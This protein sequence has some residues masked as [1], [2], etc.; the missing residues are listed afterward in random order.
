MIDGCWVDSVVIEDWKR[1]YTRRE[2]SKRRG[3]GILIVSRIISETLELR[4]NDNV[5]LER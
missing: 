1:G 4:K 3:I 2:I 5:V